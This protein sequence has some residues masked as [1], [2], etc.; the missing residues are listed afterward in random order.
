MN[1][2]MRTACVAL[3][4]VMLTGPALASDGM[5]D[6]SGFMLRLRG[7]A[8]VPDES[9]TTTIGGDGELSND[10]VPE[11]DISY[12]FTKN[13]AAELILATTT[14]DAKVKGSSMGNVDLGEVSLL[15]PTLTLQYHFTDLGNFKPYIG[16]GVNY[17]H[18]YDED[19]ANG[20]DVDYDDNFG[21]AA[22]VGLD[23]FIDENWAV[24]LDV[25][26]L[27]LNTDVSINDGAIT[28]DVDIDPWIFGV[29]VGYRF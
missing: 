12:F 1:K 23:Y 18:F 16:A 19:G 9:A 17:T 26:K 14:H 8:V 29:G 5:T 15:P 3:T 13:I 2:V 24:N 4:G 20:L 6:D 22:Q 27:W 11:L 10:Y 21:V 7:I 28:G 25:K